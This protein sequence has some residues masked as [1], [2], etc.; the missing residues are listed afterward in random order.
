LAEK[1]ADTHQL[2]VPHAIRLA[3]AR[4]YIE[5]VAHRLD[6]GEDDLQTE[7]A[8]AKLA[9]TEAGNA[10]ADAAIQALG[11]YGYTREYEV[12]KIKRDVRIT[13]IYEGTSEIMQWTIARDRWRVH[14]QGQGAF[15]KNMADELAALHAKNPQVG[16]GTASLAVRALRELFEKARA[17][18]LTRHQHVLFRLGELAMQA[19]TCAIFARAAASEGKGPRP[20]PEI[21]RAMARVYARE[22]AANVAHEGLTWL[23]GC[24]LKEDV[25]ALER[26]LLT[27]EI[28]EAQ[29]G[30]MTDL[31]TIARSLCAVESASESARLAG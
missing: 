30:L 14:L 27:R 10:A 4:A 18:R 24:D 15:Y 23:R 12:E 6:Q 11:G 29:A 9:A 17:N 7:G 3:A 26:A 22:C 28:H 31:D 21:H 1:Q 19:E 5:H 20:A 25:G 16:A 2:I 13:T 8:V